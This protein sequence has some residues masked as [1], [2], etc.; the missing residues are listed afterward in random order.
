MRQKL[1]LVCD[2]PL[3]D[4]PNTKF[5]EIDNLKKLKSASRALLYNGHMIPEERKKL[6]AS[7]ILKILP[8]ET[9]VSEELL[10]EYAEINIY[11]EN[12]NYLAH[13]KKVVDHFV[14]GNGG[15]LVQLE[16][17]WREHFLKIMKPR[18]LPE[19]WSVDHNVQRLEIRADE[20]RIEVTDLVAAGLAPELL[21]SSRENSSMASSSS[22]NSTLV[23][24]STLR[25]ME[26]QTEYYSHVQSTTLLSPS[27]DYVT[28]RSTKSDD[29]AT[30]A[31][32]SS[33]KSLE[34]T[35]KSFNPEDETVY[36][37]D[38]S[39]STLTQPSSSLDL[40]SD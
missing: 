31:S 37:S 15:G 17:M 36:E 8:D 11:K 29:D 24:A 35:L 20:G 9:E 40:D 21:N 39:D 14:T 7:E 27:R 10:Q 5:V 12:E 34:G 38:D 30:D 25:D 33:F 13:G 23:D 2:A 3:Q 32:L 18:H 4:G 22:E 26:I 6:L 16:R 19:L 1:S 28:A